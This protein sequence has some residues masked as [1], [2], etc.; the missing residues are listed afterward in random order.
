MAEGL[1]KPGYQWCLAMV[2]RAY[3]N[4][5]ESTTSIPARKAKLAESI[6]SIAKLQ[7]EV[8]GRYRM[9]SGGVLKPLLRH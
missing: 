5:V 4:A 7:L 9:P 6:L 3:S 1:P 8:E 2:Q